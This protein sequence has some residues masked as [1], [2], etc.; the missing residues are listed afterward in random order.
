MIRRN[1][2]RR[3]TLESRAQ[4][5]DGAG[6]Y[7]V[8]WQSR[9]IL[10]AA[11]EPGAGRDAGGVEV[12]RAETAYRIT[13]RGAP[14]GAPSRPVPGQRFRDSARIFDILAVTERDAGGRYLTCFA[15]EEVPT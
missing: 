7:A 5:P 12:V 1:L 11:V 2:N 14:Q 6:G 8:A 10:W 3:L 4:V 9:G 15:R 13:V